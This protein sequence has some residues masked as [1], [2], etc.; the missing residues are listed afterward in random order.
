VSSP[1]VEKQEYAD[2]VLRIRKD[3]KGY[4]AT[5]SGPAEAGSGPSEPFPSPFKDRDIEEL[6][7]FRGS[8]SRDLDLPEKTA[9][10]RVAELG[11]ELFE[12]VFSEKVRRLWDASLNRARSEKRGLRLRLIL[13]SSELWEW[14]W[15]YLRDPDT[16]FLIFSPDISVVR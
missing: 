1:L 7:V 14:P 5:P 15:E 4:V 16:D 9:R 8:G 2:F 3:S 11:R 6:R 13:E 10:S 12:T